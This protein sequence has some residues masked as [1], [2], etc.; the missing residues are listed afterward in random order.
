MKTSYYGFSEPFRPKPKPTFYDWFDYRID[1]DR[2]RDVRPF[3]S[4]KTIPSGCSCIRQDST[5]TVCRF[6]NNLKSVVRCELLNVDS[7]EF[8]C[9][10]NAIKVC[11]DFKENFIKHEVEC[12]DE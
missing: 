10:L 5:K 7:K 3:M 11:L 9:L 4:R 1:T 2:V 6:Y 8:P 12:F